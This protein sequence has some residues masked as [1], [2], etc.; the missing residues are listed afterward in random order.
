MC[1][2]F[3]QARAAQKAAK[4]FN[5]P[6]PWDI[7]PNYN[8]APSLPVTAIRVV[9]AMR[10]WSLLRWGLV[11][12]W[13]K[14]VKT[15]YKMINA[16]AETVAEKPAYRAAFRYRRCVIPADGFYE[17]QT[18]ADGKQPYLIRLADESPMLFAG[19]WES[20]EHDG[21]SLETCAIITTDAS[22]QMAHVH[23]R[24][25]VVLAPEACQIWLDDTYQDRA[26]LQ[27]L[28]VPTTQALTTYP[29]DRR[30][31]KPANNDEACMTPI[32]E[33]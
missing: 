4:L 30:V 26:H 33:P 9:H 31:N 3:L 20:W 11:P 17:W 1:G 18:R 23:D 10:E 24:M 12:H 13:A 19:L 29:V 32:A 15:A 5:L 28:L 21:S 2:R 22:P 16:K 14:E 25:P 27:A 7:R 8:L 6:L